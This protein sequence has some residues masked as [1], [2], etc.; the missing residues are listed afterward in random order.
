EQPPRLAMPPTVV[1]TAVPNN[2][3]LSNW[4]RFMPG[5]SAVVSGIIIVVLG[6]VSWSA[7]QQ[8]AQ[9][10]LY[11]AAVG[12]IQHPR[13]IEARLAQYPLGLAEGQKPLMTMVMAHAGR[14]DTAKG[15]IAYRDMQQGL[16]Q[17][18]AAGMGLL[19]Y[20]LL[21]TPV[22][23]KIVERQRART[24]IDIG[25][26]VVDLPVGHDRQQWAEYLILHHQHVIADIQQQG[27]GQASL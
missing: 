23:A 25:D 22:V 10:F 4:R 13:G 18:H 16:V 5:A 20:P 26:G 12:R 9:K 2:P 14:P 24:G 7:N 1:R 3:N 21:L 6:R 8:L 15:Q 17:A 11:G 19:H 27:R